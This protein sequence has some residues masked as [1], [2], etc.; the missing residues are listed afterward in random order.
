MEFSISKLQI[1]L[2]KM[3]YQLEALSTLWIYTKG[4]EVKNQ[5]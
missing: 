4:S 3:Y 1:N 5:M 2:K